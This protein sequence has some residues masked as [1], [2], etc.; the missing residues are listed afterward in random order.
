MVGVLDR[1]WTSKRPF[2][3]THIILTKTLGIRRAQDIRPW[4]TLCIDFWERG[5][6]SGLIGDADPEGDAREGSAA[7]GGEE[8]DDAVPRSYHNTVLSSKLRQAVCW[9]TN[10][11]GRDCL[12]PGD[13]CTKTGRP[14]AE[15][16]REKHPDMH[17]PPVEN[18]T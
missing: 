1:S 16:L 18:P 4:I 10:R 11:E 2:V 6:H 7:N 14:V 5:L 17:V 3:F 9:A 13:Q 15:V 12:L 8:E